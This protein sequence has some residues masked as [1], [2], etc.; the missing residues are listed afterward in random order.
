MQST[1]SVAASLL[2][3]LSGCGSMAPS[4]HADFDAWLVGEPDRDYQF[5]ELE[6]RSPGEVMVWSY[7]TWP[8]FMVRDVLRWAV[9]PVVY[10]YFL[11]VG[12]SDQDVERA[13]N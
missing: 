8:V 6:D 7:A 3:A 11:F 2:L 9:T 5:V 12:K 10:P 13:G 4:R 1:L